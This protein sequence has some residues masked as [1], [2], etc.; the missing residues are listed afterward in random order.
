[1]KC[2]PKKQEAYSIEAVNAGLRHHLK[3]PARKSHFLSGRIQALMKNIRLFVYSYSHR[4]V[5][6][7]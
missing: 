2:G 3:L 7:I 1:M 4:Q 6:S 5:V